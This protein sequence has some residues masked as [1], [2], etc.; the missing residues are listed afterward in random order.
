MQDKKAPLVVA[1]FFWGRVMVSI[2]RTYLTWMVIGWSMQGCTC[3]VSRLGY[4]YRKPASLRKQ[5]NILSFCGK[6]LAPL[7][8]FFWRLE[9]EF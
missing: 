4:R 8:A 5:A 1:F 7:G 3:Y 2:K 9:R 6:K